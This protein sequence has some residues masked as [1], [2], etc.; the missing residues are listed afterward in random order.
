MWTRVQQDQRRH[1]ETQAHASSGHRV[2]GDER[3]FPRRRRIHPR[4]PVDVGRHVAPAEAVL[5]EFDEEAV[6]TVPVVVVAGLLVAPL[7]P[8]AADQFSIASAGRGVVPADVVGDDGTENPTHVGIQAVARGEPERVL[9]LQRV[10][11]VEPCEGVGRVVGEH[12][13]VAAPFDVGQAQLDPRVHDKRPVAA[14][15]QHVLIERVL[16]HRIRPPV[17][18]V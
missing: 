4:E 10:R 18:W 15:R 12:G 6:A 2:T 5:A 8:L 13:R 16:R 17:D 14:P 9:A 3:E 1:L 11:Q 7:S